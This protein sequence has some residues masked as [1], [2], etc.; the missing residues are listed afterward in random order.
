MLVFCPQDTFHQMLSAEVTENLDLPLKWFIDPTCLGPMN[1]HVGPINQL[2]KT[3][4]Y[5]KRTHFQK[6]S[7][8]LFNIEHI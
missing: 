4:F 5:N 3:L 6:H 2:I 1:H 7:N 8:I